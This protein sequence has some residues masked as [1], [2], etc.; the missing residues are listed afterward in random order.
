MVSKAS[1]DFP[2]PDSPVNT[3]SWSRGISRSTFLRL[4]SRAPRIEITRAPSKEARGDAGERRGR[5]LSKRSFM[6]VRRA[7]KSGGYR[8]VEEDVLTQL[9]ARD[10][11]NVVRTGAFR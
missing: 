4:C 2:E 8:A 11:R 5:L 9:P 3:T 10:T 6:Q 7:V 1:E